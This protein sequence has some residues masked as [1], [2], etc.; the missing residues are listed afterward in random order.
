MIKITTERPEHAGDIEILLDAAFGTDRHAKISYSFRQGVDRVM[1][2]C[3]V[4]LDDAGPDG[5]QLAGTIRFW[6]ILIGQ[7]QI[8]RAHV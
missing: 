5:C 7:N 3:L 4:A 2:L 8:G 6:P 1:P